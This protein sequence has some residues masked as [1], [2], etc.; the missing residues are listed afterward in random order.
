MASNKTLNVPPAFVAN[1]AGNLFNVG[2]TSGAVGFTGA[3]PYAILQHIRLLNKTGGA[4]SVTLYKGAT[5]GSAS[6]TERY[7]AG[8]SIPANSY[9]DWFGKDRYDSADFL[10]G[11]AGSASAI[12][13]EIDG[14][15]GIA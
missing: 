4:V 11:V 14:E 15:I 9:V 10:S 7:F 3:N 1:A 13:I 5:G 12:V 8:V 2:T 6:G